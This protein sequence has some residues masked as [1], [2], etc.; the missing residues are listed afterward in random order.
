MEKNSLNLGTIFKPVGRVVDQGQ[1]EAYLVTSS[2]VGDALSAAVCVVSV[3]SCAA[4]DL[5][6]LISDTEKERRRRGM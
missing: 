1:E 3:A 2:L 5:C 6:S 4:A